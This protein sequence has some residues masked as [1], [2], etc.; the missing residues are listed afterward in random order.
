MKIGIIGDI[1]IGCGLGFSRPSGQ[2][3]INPR[4]IDY[5]T[6]LNYTIDD[7]AD[8]GVKNIVLTGDIF[9]S[10]QPSLIQ[11]KIFAQAIHRAIAGG[12]EGIFICVGN[13]DQ[14][15]LSES[16]TVSWLQ[17]LNL[18]NV[19]VFDD[20]ATVP[21]YEG[22]QQ[23]ANLILMPFRDRKWLGTES[24]EEAIGIIEKQLQFQLASIENRSVMSLAVGHYCIEGTM[25]SS[26]ED[27]EFYGENQLFLPKRLFN[28]VDITINGHCHA[29]A[30]ISTNPYIAYVGSMEKRSGSETHNKL[31]A[32]VD[33]STKTVEYRKEP[34]REIYDIKLDYSHLTLG[35]KLQERIQSDID[36]FAQSH[37]M[38]ESIVKLA[39]KINMVDNEHV[40]PKLIYRFLKERHHIHNC[41][42]LR[43]ELFSARQSRNDRINEQ[44]GD[45]EA[46][47]LFLDASIEDK[48]LRMEVLL[49]GTDIIKTME[50]QDATG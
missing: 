10:R 35:K 11:Q 7:L 6:T 8:S 27:L 23:I 13:H 24:Y 47:R 4:L 28:D 22:R 25:F 2:G 44:M 15:R 50:A 34:C 12:I 40:S 38:V 43:P 41:V 18:P 1:H 29:P 42:E 3:V 33:T 21:V 46:F 19:K 16:T 48:E 37:K 32:I 31:Y 17:E 20:M 30:I 49:A 14:S 45:N 5:Q 26:D 9:E 39:L 36:E